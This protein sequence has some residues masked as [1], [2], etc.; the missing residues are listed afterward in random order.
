MAEIKRIPGIKTGEIIRAA[1]LSDMAR[2]INELSGFIDRPER[3]KKLT[4]GDTLSSD[5]VKKETDTTVQLPDPAQ[6]WTETSR[7]EE[8]V[9]VTSPDDEEVWV[10]VGRMRIVQSSNLLGEVEYRVYA[11]GTG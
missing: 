1:Y 9:R 8:T 4:S 7:Y 3:Q 6:V 10:D 5:P 2:A 11:E